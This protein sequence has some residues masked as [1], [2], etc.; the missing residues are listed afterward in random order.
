M[1]KKYL[2]FSNKLHEYTI[3]SKLR[4]DNTTIHTLSHSHGEQWSETTKGKKCL[5]IIEGDLE[6]EIVKPKIGMQSYSDIIEMKLLIDFITSK[7]NNDE[8]K[9]IE[10]K[11]VNK[12]GN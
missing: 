10:E 5:Q 12:F 1:K 3:V 6:M 11:N 4:D 2:V 9:V 7:Y 8:F